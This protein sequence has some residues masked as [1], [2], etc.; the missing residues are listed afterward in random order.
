[1]RLPSLCRLI[2]VGACDKGEDLQQLI[3]CVSREERGKVL[4]DYG[5]AYFL[6]KETTAKLVWSKLNP[7]EGTSNLFTR[8]LLQE[9]MMSKSSLFYDKC[10]FRDRIVS[11]L[12]HSM[13]LFCYDQNASVVAAMSV[14]VPDT[15]AI[16]ASIVQACSLQDPTK[17][18]ESFDYADMDHQSFVLEFACS[19]NQNSETKRGLG[20][21]LV[22]AMR[23]SICNEFFP[24]YKSMFD[25]L[26]PRP[27]CDML[28]TIVNACVVHLIALREAMPFWERVDFRLIDYDHQ[29]ETRMAS[30]IVLTTKS[31]TQLETM[32]RM[33]PPS[34]LG[35]EITED[36]IGR[37]INSMIRFL[38]PNA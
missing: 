15:K 1:M 4:T 10:E 14:S 26:R 2:E 32:R 27:T 35:E 8:H 31:R 24:T 25:E 34:V 9:K 17:L 22:A 30:Y 37:Q 11:D 28:E 5:Y 19:I 20:R 3:Q 12:E 7:V 13:T 36:L 29:T 38:Q 6:P 16:K 18:L 33:T 23:T 21:G